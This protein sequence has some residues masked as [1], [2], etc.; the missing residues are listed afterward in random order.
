MCGRFALPTIEGIAQYFNLKEE[1]NFGP[2]YNIAPSQD[3]A[4]VR[5]NPDTADRELVML[6]WGL[7]PFWAKDKKIGYKMIKAR[8]ESV[9]EKPAFR[10]VFKR[11]RCLIPALGFYEW[12]HKTK[13]NQPYFIRLK[14]SDV[15]A[16]A[17]L[18][19][20]WEGEGDEVID[21]C[22]ILSRPRQ[23]RQ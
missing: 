8:A 5:I 11:S 7:I 3:I 1:P 14:D 20:H 21:S 23:T 18:W 10:A 12:D 9:A 13:T 6:H 2:R 22:T 16:F 4:V 15:L 19:E 17:G